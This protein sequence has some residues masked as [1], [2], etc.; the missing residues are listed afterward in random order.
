MEKDFLTSFSNKARD[1]TGNNNQNITINN[2][3]SSHEIRQLRERIDSLTEL[4]K[5]IRIEKTCN[6]ICNDIIAIRDP[7]RNKN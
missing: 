7:D 3:T 2:Y 5:G 4:I 1:I 6:G